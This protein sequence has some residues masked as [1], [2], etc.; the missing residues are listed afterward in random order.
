MAMDPWTVMRCVQIVTLLISVARTHARTH[1]RAH[2]LTQT[3]P[4][5]VEWELGLS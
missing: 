5:A 4:I 3:T 2:T 1:A